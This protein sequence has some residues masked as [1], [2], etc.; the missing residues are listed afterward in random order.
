MTSLSFRARR[1]RPGIRKIRRRMSLR[2]TIPYMKE[3]TK[4]LWV[5]TMALVGT[6]IGVG[7][8]AVPFA[9]DRVGVTLGAVYF[10]LL[11]GIQM[12]QHLFYAEASIATPGKRRLV[13]LVEIHLGK[14]ARHLASWAS[15][16]GF[17][18]AM[19]AYN[20]LG[21]TFLHTLFGSLIGGEEWH[22]QLAW[23]LIG[24]LLIV[25]GLGLVSK[26]EFWMTL[27]LIAAMMMIF[28]IGLPHVR[29][30]NFHFVARGDIFLPYGIILFALNGLSAVPEMQDIV[31]G[32]KTSLRL[33]VL[34]GSLIATVLNAMFAFGAWGVTGSATTQDAVSGL[35]SSLGPG[36]TMIAALFGFLAVATSYLTT[37]I[38]LRETFQYDYAMAKL[39]S[40]LLAVG[41]PLIVFLFGAESIIGIIGFTGA[42]FGGI[43]AVLVAILYITV[44]RRGLVKDMPLGVSISLAR[45]SILIL[46]IGAGYE[47]LTTAQKLLGN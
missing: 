40:W 9:L 21:G 45:L 12:L 33:S 34:L 4:S 42:V 8:F 37:A 23:S 6:I 3:S 29:L 5:A 30:S 25:R 28:A 10:L 44:A 22:Y 20:L 39:P 18:G 16:F 41:V 47:V 7:I 17:W 32:N 35:R 19:I 27:G 36:I 2:G 13:G 24:G 26:I 31:A 38:N 1:R 43:V 15:I 11:G 46:V 14:N